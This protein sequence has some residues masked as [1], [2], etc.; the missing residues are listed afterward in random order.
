MTEPGAPQTLARD[1]GATIAY[2]RTEGR[3]PGVVFLTGFRSDMTGGKA[4]ALE[5]W[6]RERDRAFLRFD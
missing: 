3:T 6:C 2:H 4:T 1:D 5:A